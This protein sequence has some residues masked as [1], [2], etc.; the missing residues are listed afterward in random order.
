[1]NHFIYGGA[2]VYKSVIFFVT[3]AIFMVN[4]RKFQLSCRDKNKILV[5][6][7]KLALNNYFD[8]QRPEAPHGRTSPLDVTGSPIS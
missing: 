5:F 7:E 3:H 6:S 4:Q 2:F 1:M 8:S